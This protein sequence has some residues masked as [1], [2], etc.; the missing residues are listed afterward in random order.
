MTNNRKKL[1]TYAM[2]GMFGLWAADS[3]IFTPLGRAWKGR[4]DRIASLTKSRNNGM[5]LIDRERPIRDYWQSIRTN[6]L[7]SDESVS[8]GIVMKS[9]ARWQ[10]ESGIGFRS[11]KPQ[12]KKQDDDYGTIE[13]RVDA[14]GDIDNVAKF[15]YALEA[16]SLP[17][18]VESLEITSRDS[19]GRELMI[20][21]RFSGLLL[22]S[23]KNEKR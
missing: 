2:L 18:K 10:D 14:T 9:A 7:P 13:F 8:E 21:V 11:R 20:G 19:E 16:D 6:A 3:M 17:V 15:I 5:L 22:T 1:L 12:W 4:S 23:E